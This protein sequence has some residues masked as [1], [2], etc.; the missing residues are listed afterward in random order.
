MLA[1]PIAFS[2]ALVAAT[3][4]VSE[5]YLFQVGLLTT[6]GLSAK[7]AILIVEFASPS[8]RPQG[9]GGCDA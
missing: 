6:I 4:F 7:N 9:S 3:T 8:R 2:V 1:V 5:R